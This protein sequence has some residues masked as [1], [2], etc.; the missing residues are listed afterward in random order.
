MCGDGHLAYPKSISEMYLMTDIFSAKTGQVT[1]FN[2]LVG[3]ERVGL[4]NISVQDVV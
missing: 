2:F 1:G 4:F 3:L